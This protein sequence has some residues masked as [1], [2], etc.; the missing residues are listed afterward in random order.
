[1]LVFQV[2]FH[3]SLIGFFERNF[4]IVACGFLQKY[5]VTAVFVR[6]L[7]VLGYALACFSVSL[8]AEKLSDIH[9]KEFERMMMETYHQYQLKGDLLVGLISQDGL[10]Y[11]FTLNQN[12]KKPEDNGLTSETPFLIASHTK[13]FTGTLAQIFAQQK[14]VD[15]DAP[16][17]RYLDAELQDERIAKNTIKVK[18]LLNHTAGF[19]SIQHTFKTA[20]L[21]YQNEEDWVDSLNYKTLVAEPGQ[22]RYSNTGPILYAK[23]LENTASLSWPSLMEKHLF[24]PLEM[25]DTSASISRYKASEI[26]P[27]ISV[28]K[29][30]EVVRKGV[31]KTDNTMHAAGGT[32]STLGDMAKWLSFNIR[33]DKSL[34]DN[35]A[36]FDTLHNAT[37]QQSKKYFTYERSGYSLGWDIAEYRQQSLLSRFGGFAGMSFHAS[38]MPDAKLGVVAF[39]NDERAYVLPHLAANLLYNFASAPDEAIAIFEEEKKGFEKSFNNEV[40][41]AL[42]PKKRVHMKSS[43]KKWLGDYRSDASWPE[44]EL[45]ECED[46]VCVR[47]GVLDG[48]LYYLDETEQ[49]YLVDLGAIKRKIQLQKTDTGKRTLRNGSLVFSKR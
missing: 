35:P 49:R 9:Q 2:R 40:N 24:S 15:L 10:I 17:S 31:F 6:S 13:A 29:S 11:Q 5:K 18:Q 28:S 36:F 8:R 44:I 34:S 45:L 26:L 12:G 1:M 20:F 30:G 23:A 19:T 42:N 21:G 41:R 7:V 43:F 3:V 48:P 33:Q 22:F 25:R 46:G 47:W 16:L 37:T 27:S 39:F 4:L 14:T 32:V 38:F